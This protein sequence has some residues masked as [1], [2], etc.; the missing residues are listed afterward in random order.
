MNAEFMK[1]MIEFE[2]AAEKAGGYVIQPEYAYN[3]SDFE[4]DFAT[5]RRYC[6]EHKKRLIDLTEDDWK[7][8][9]IAPFPRE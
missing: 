5:Y 6:V 4:N 3:D 7:A 1:S 8:M 2:I 9:E